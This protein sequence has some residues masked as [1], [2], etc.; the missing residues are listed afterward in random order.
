LQK[1]GLSY[2]SSVFPIHHH[3]YG[4]PDSD[5][6]PHWVSF[7]GCR[8]KEF[9][10]STVRRMGRNMPFSGGGYFRLLPV[11]AI[12]A[13]IRNLNRAGR[14]AM[15]YLHPWEFD[16]DQPRPSGLPSG[17]RWRCYVGLKHTERKLRRLLGEFRF[18]PASDVLHSCLPGPRMPKVLEVNLKVAATS[19]EEALVGQTAGA[20]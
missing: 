17:K 10:I 4:V 6:F 7:N 13:G 1:L 8:I 9:P 16:P 5:R 12:A 11:A 3:R 15:L 14:P 19:R 20:R 18:S 2:D